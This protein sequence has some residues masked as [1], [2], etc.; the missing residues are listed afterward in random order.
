MVDVLFCSTPWTTGTITLAPAV[1]KSVSVVA[2]FNARAID[3]AAIITKIIDEHPQKTQIIRFLQTQDIDVNCYSGIVDIL[4]KSA[5]IVLSYHPKIIGLSVL[6]QESQIFTL[7]FSYYLKYISPQTKIIVGGSG[8]KN[9]IADSKVFY[10]DTLRTMEFIDDFIVGDGELAVVE[11]LKNNLDYPGINSNTWEQLDNLERFPYPDFSDYDFSV[12]KTK[13]IPICDSRGCVR[14]CEFCDIIEHWTK[15]KYRSAEHVFSEMLYQINN[16]GIT[17]FSF[18]NSLTNGNMRVFEKLL[19]L[20]IEYNSDKPKNQQISW[21][22]YFIIRPQEAHPES[23]W[24]KLKA[25]NA[26]LFLGV[27]SVV[28]HVRIGLGKNFK[29]VDIDYHLQMAQKY[30]VSLYLLLIV[31]YPTE[32]KNDFEYTKKWFIDREQYADIIAGSATTLCAILPGTRLERNM[33]QYNID[34]NMTSIPVSWALNRN[35]EVVNE[36][37][38]YTYLKELTAIMNKHGFNPCV[39]DV[40]VSLLDG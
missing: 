8:V 9:F 29:N 7:W 30:K 26:R 10:A 17:D 11:Y 36:Q 27:E 20:I 5:E 22:G 18:Y 19:D 40:T 4:K 15:Y 13:T 31:G 28:E 3:L 25:S 14:K 2:G 33:Q 34:K 21:N 1:L 39:D 23:I 32:T 35:N 38:R 12:Y 16:T 37:D 24:P 6:S